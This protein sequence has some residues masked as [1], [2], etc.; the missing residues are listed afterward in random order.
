MTAA[1]SETSPSLGGSGHR[2]LSSESTAKFVLLWAS[3]LFPCRPL[4]CFS[5]TSPGRQGPEW[6]VCPLG[7][8]LSPPATLLPSSVKTLNFESPAQCP[9][10][11]P[12]RF[13][14]TSELS[15]AHLDPGQE[16]SSRAGHRGYPPGASAR[17]LG[18][19]QARLT[20]LAW[21]PGPPGWGGGLAPHRICVR[22]LSFQV[23]S[24]GRLHVAPLL[25]WFTCGFLRI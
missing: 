24:K 11:S 25:P 17:P 1:S 21:V 20:H 9:P 19:P 6:D 14:S 3:R 4:Q 7:S 13:L 2:A 18:P 22:G 8:S 12:P 16:R 5:S 10:G 15:R 23:L